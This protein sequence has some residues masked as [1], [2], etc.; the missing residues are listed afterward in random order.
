MDKDALLTRLHSLTGGLTPAPGSRSDEL[1]LLQRN[2]LEQLAINPDLAVSGNR[3]RQ[4]FTQPVAFTEPSS[5]FSRLLDRLAAQAAT[6]LPTVTPLVFRRETVFNSSLLG[7]SVPSWGSGL[8]PTQTYGPFLDERGLKIWFDFFFPI[9]TVQ[10][11]QQGSTT[12]ILLLPIRG[13]LSGRQSFNVEAG[14]AW[15][16]SGLIANTPA[17]AGYYTGLKIR[18]GTLDLSQS[19]AITAGHIVVPA[20]AAL[21]L[22]LDLDQKAAPPAPANAGFDAAHAK[23]SMPQTFQLRVPSAGSSIT[24]GAAS[25]TVFGCEV[26]F[27]IRNTPPAWIASI[28][29]ILVSYSAKS[30][31]QTPDTFNVD[32]SESTLCSLSGRATFDV[33]C[34][35]LLPAAKIDPAQLGRAAGTGAMCITLGKGLSADWKGLTGLGTSLVH[36]AIIV[37]P[38]L[39]TTVDFFA[40]NVYGKQKWLLWRNA[41]SGHHSDVTLRF[42][43]AFPFIFISSALN[44]ES[45]FCFCS[46]ISA[47]DRPVDANGAPFRLESSV[48]FAGILQTG[49]ELQALLLD[50]DTLFDGNTNKPDAFDHFS[51]ALRNAFFD[52]SRPYSFFLTGKLENEGQITKGAVT[53][54]FGVYRYYPTLPDPYVASFTAALSIRPGARTFSSRGFNELVSALACSIKWPDPEMTSRA[55]EHQAGDPDDPAY[56]YFRIVPLD[57]L[58]VASTLEAGSPDP[59]IA[60]FDRSVPVAQAP[61]NF[62]TGVRSFNAPLSAVEIAPEPITTIAPFTQAA[63]QSRASSF[64]APAMLPITSNAVTSEQIRSAVASLE[65][66]PL[67]AHIEDKAFQINQTLNVA[68]PNRAFAV[69]AAFAAPE[70]RGTSTNFPDRTLIGRSLFLL[71]DVSSNA[72]QMGVSF[73]T[74]IF[75]DRDPNGETSVRTVETRPAAASIGNSFSLQIDN[76]DVVANAQ[77][78]ASSPCHKS[79]GS[80]SST[81]RWPSRTTPP[82]SITTAPGPVVFDNDG[83]PTIIAST[84]PYQAPVAP[85]PATRHFLKEF[86]DKHVPRSL[87]AAFTLPFGMEAEASFNRSTKGRPEDWSRLHFNQPYFPE[88]HGGFQIKA[89][90]PASSSTKM[91]PYFPGATIQLDN[92]LKWG[93]F[94]VSLTGGALGKTVG[95]IFNR[96]FS[97][98][99]NKPRVPVEQMEISG[100]G[101]SMFSHWLDQDAAIAQVSQASFD[102]LMG[103]T[104]HEVVQVRSILFPFGV[105][106]VRTI[107]FT[108]S[109]NGYVFRS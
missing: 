11:F 14:S 21:N 40:S 5:D 108:R 85:L 61:R 20:L 93:F 102:V 46:Y 50:T 109:S 68:A 1:P 87:Y 89:Q 13:P 91:R 97:P 59:Q 106:V 45:V 94:G 74:S 58:A 12:P 27:Q 39:V 2:L 65:A 17:L 16:A 32:S 95:G 7:N 36:P 49:K 73:G 55:A 63:L 83:I 104:A 4:E 107:T 24:A 90:A 54:H 26:D 67:L 33:S 82:I 30:N 84:S 62:Q 103:R 29:Q 18:V 52:V 86:N 3:T 38:G 48:A 76:M 6:Q 37:E 31:S 64:T 66:N 57:Q 56:V 80:R 41:G 8:A 78:F 53:L 9:R 98:S 10:V 51:L 100:Y 88:L 72:D 28:G 79:P 81:S 23:V 15:I 77:N 43:K 70:T 19:A 99:G 60:F 42:G 75:V 35:W 92:N 34:G 105:H 96:E 47:F 25:C 69:E 22:H 44:S 101:A 71:L